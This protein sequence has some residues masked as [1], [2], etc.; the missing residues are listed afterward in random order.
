MNGAIK[1]QSLRVTVTFHVLLAVDG[2]P[3][4]SSESA[5]DGAEDPVPPA[6]KGIPEPQDTRMQLEQCSAAPGGTKIPFA[7]ELSL[8]W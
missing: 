4:Q 2:S 7:S 3:W 6:G 5:L 1:D 8:P